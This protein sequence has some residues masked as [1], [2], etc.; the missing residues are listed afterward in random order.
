V[1]KV[2]ICETFMMMYGQHEVIPE[3]F[4][5]IIVKLDACLSKKII[6]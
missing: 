3:H 5:L 4:A 1:V 6:A 2:S